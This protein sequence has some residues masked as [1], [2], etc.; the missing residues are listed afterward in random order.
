MTPIKEFL[1]WLMRRNKDTRDRPKT[2]SPLEALP[3]PPGRT[4]S[5]SRESA[6]PSAT[7]PLKTEII[8]RGHGPPLAWLVIVSGPRAGRE[9]ALH[10]GVFT[11]GR[12]IGSDIILD[13]VTVSGQHARI[14]YQDG[15]FI[16]YD[17]AS[18][19]GTLVNN[20]QILKHKLTDGDLVG[21]G[22][23][24]LV[25][26]TLFVRDEVEQWYQMIA[27]ALWLQGR[28]AVDD[29][30][31]PP[32]QYRVGLLKDYVD[33]HPGL[34]L[35]YREREQVLVFR[36]HLAIESL[37]SAW[38]EFLASEDLSSKS[39]QTATMVQIL[40]ESLG[41]TAPSQPDI[42]SLGQ[43]WMAWL[44]VAP[45]FEGLNIAQTLPVVFSLSSELQAQ[46]VT[47]IRHLLTYQSPGAT[48]LCLVLLPGNREELVQAQAFLY[49][50]LR[51]PFAIDGV[52]AGVDQ[53]LQVIAS[54]R[55]HEQLRRLILSG[56]ELTTVS[57]FVV[58]AP[59]SDAVFVG[60]E[61]E[62]REIS[63]HAATASYGIIG[64]RRVGKTSI[65]HRLHR[66]RLPVAGF[67]TSYH[68][69]STT[70]TYDTFLAAAIRDWRPE[71]P[72]GAPTTFNDLLQSPPDDKLLVLLLDEA[73]KLV[74]ADR[75]GGWPLFYALRALA[76]SGHAQ[77]VLSG[78]RTL[79]DALRDPQSPLFN[80]T[81]E[82]LLG[83]LDYRAVE[84]LVTR[85]M[86]QLEIELLD[87]KAIVDRVWA[88]TSGHPN[89][90]Q[91]LC[92]RLI[93]RLN[94]QGTRRI[95]LDDVDAI[96]EDPGFQRDDFLSTYWEAA[97][98]LEKIISLLMADDEEVRTLRVVRQA[99]AERCNLQ[100]K[101]REVDDALQ[102]LVD[103]RSILKRAPTGY[104]FAVTAFPRV[105]AGTMTLA[106]MLEVLVEDYADEQAK[107]RDS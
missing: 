100:P 40:G 72:P 38:S 22:S 93:E 67:R 79:R 92:R 105:V 9:F 12:S 53:M 104:E 21:I 14:R 48:R 42:V 85:P 76:N 32:M 63:E 70:D 66:V 13:D 65:L 54:K 84:E 16:L 39:N 89:V 52:A 58:Q 36:D 78:E 27:H 62:L 82:I 94:E 61:S 46:D 23:T 83:P 59:V 20:Q 95:T 98:P 60:R 43:L 45:A 31:G 33:D 44:D 68:D 107:V 19:N 34:A 87:E 6:T 77:V 49:E 28:I 47:D 18:S 26:K 69:C 91:R 50:K 51:K 102:R 11:I 4:E 24:R 97:T 96:I 35:E 106:D 64:G 55:P 103:L 73:D 88:F 86:K 74:P 80:F 57:P 17:L 56:I 71:P 41:M 25:F 7:P 90:V 5:A 99:L 29:F 81:N 3:S 8:S 15:Q 30:D 10:D 2:T 1:N 75:S 37:R 101:A